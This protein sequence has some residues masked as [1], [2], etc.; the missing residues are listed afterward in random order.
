MGKTV[1]PVIKK[2]VKICGDSHTFCAHPLYGEMYNFGDGELAFFHQHLEGFDYTPDANDRHGQKGVHRD[3]KIMLTR[4]LDGGETWP[5]SERVVVLDQSMSVEEKRSMLSWNGKR[6]SV[7]SL[8]KREPAPPVT[9][10]TVFH[11]GQ[12]FAGPEIEK[13]CY[14]LRPFMIRSEDRGRTWNTD[15][16]VEPDWNGL[17][18]T[19]L[20]AWPTMVTRPGKFI[21]PFVISTDPNVDDNSPS[22]IYR[23]V[24]FSS[25]DGG[26]CWQYM[27][28]AARD[29]NNEFPHSYPQLVDMGGNNLI[30]TTGSW[31]RHPADARW[32]SICYSD[33]LGLN[34]TKPRVIHSHGVAPY[35][36]LLRD[37]RLLVVYARR[38]PTSLTG[39]YGIISGDNGKTWSDEFVLRAGDDGGPD[40]GYP[41]TTQ[42]PNGDIFMGYYYTEK[43]YARGGARYIAGTIFSV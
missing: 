9:P 2:H 41:E 36:L 7:H 21:K 1:K 16:P 34:W 33:D 10:D 3:A 43:G 30:M 17:P 40:I 24:L 35:P 22:V 23:A 13:D 18:F 42:L 5:E 19:Y 6:G 20:Q 29:T 15:K 12:V 11:W 26:V 38:V 32:I 27:S 14:A 37:G 25:E 8:S 39:L 4:S 31:F 28:E